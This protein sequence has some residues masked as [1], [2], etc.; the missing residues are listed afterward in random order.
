MV[1]DA[2]T[3]NQSRSLHP[4]CLPSP[5]TETVTQ[6]QWNQLSF[7]SLRIQ[8]LAA[9]LEYWCASETVAAVE[10]LLRARFHPS[11]RGRSHLEPK[12]PDHT[13]EC[14]LCDYSSSTV[15]KPVE[16][17]TSSG[18]VNLPHDGPASDLHRSNLILPRPLRPGLVGT[19]PV[20]YK[21]SPAIASASLNAS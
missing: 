13:S 10:Q 15:K 6:T 12:N 21:T 9:H 3:F 5:S 14:S 4:H 8:K 11:F 7:F 18:T 20:T 19:T 1:L 2:Q 17:T 16:Q